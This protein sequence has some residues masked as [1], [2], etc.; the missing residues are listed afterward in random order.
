[1][2]EKTN[3]KNSTFWQIRTSVQKRI[4]HVRLWTLLL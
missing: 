3:T 4:S 2:D 1:M